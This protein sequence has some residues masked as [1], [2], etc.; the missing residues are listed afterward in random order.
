MILFVITVKD[1]MTREQI[2]EI[3]DKIMAKGKDNWDADDQTA[4]NLCLAIL[5]EMKRENYETER[6]T[7]ER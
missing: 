5:K 3:L 6:I 4:I 2:D 1:G 7:K